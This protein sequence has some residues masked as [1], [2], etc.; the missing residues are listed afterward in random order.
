MLNFR[1]RALTQTLFDEF[2]PDAVM[3]LAAES[4]V[5]RSINGSADFVQTNIVGTHALLESALAYWDGIRDAQRKHRFR[6]LP[7]STDEVFGS[8]ANACRLILLHQFS[9]QTA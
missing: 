7:V 4:H 8:L 1:Y 3:H 5:D 9:V 6:F 2:A